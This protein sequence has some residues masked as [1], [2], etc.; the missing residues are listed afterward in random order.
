MKKVLGIGNAIV[1][2]LTFIDNDNLIK[3]LGI[4][5]G[6]MQLIDTKE[7]KVISEK[8]KGKGKKMVAGG[9]AANTITGLSKLGVET[10]FIGKIG[11]DEVGQFFRE[12]SLN[13]G[14]K[15]QMKHSDLP[16]GQ[17]QVLVSPDKERTMCTYLGAACELSPEDLEEEMFAG[18]DY[19]HIEGYLVQN[20]A[21]LEKAVKL[22]RKAG[23]KVSLDLA[24]Y[25]V[26]EENLEFLQSLVK[27][28]VNIVFAN[29]EEAKSFTQMTP[30]ESV[31][32]ISNICDIAVVKVGKRGSLIKSGKEECEVMPISANCIDTTGAGDLYASG[33]LYGLTQGYALDKCGKIGSLTAGKV[34]EFAGS[35]IDDQTWE[36]IKGEIKKL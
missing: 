15:V 22:A 32:K 27:E 7:I 30:E 28:Y 23:A 34:I 13:N 19:F 17:C 14:I 26:V 11:D 20:H 3:E 10:S 29:E 25:N 4:G 12:D 35:K 31:K 33:F 2:V 36:E 1:D 5:K 6:S 24:S 18:Y 21:L 9:S 8:T 16:S